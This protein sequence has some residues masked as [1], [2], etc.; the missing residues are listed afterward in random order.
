MSDGKCPK[1]GTRITAFQAGFKGRKKPF[2]CRGCGQKIQKANSE[3]WLAM[4]A[5]AAFWGIKSQTDDIAVLAAVFFAMCAVIVLKSM[6]RA[7]IE[8]ADAVEGMAQEPS[9]S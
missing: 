2:E 8:L 1:C 3:L 4:G 5:F 6:Y 9:S 7:Q